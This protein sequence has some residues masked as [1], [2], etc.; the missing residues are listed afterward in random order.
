MKKIISSVLALAMVLCIFP[1]AGISA[2]AAVS[3]TFTYSVNNGIATITD[4]DETVAGTV[5]IPSSLGGYTV[6]EIGDYAFQNCQG[7]TGV[8]IGSNITK[9]GDY[10]FRNCKTLKS[11]SIPNNVVE[12]GYSAFEGCALLNSATIGS[13]LTA[14]PSS[15]FNGC[16]NLET[17]KIGSNVTEI[18]S[19]AFNNCT[20]LTTITWGSNLKKINSSAFYGCSS[21]TSLSIPNTVVTIGDYAFQNCTGLTSLTI[22][23]KVNTIGDYAFRGCSRIKTVTVPNSVTSLGYDT[24][25]GCTLLNSIKIGSGL[26]TIPSSM[27]NGCA[28]LKEVTIGENVTEIGSSAFNNCTGLATITWGSNLKKINSSAFYGCSSLTSLSI[29]NTVVTIGDYAFQNC[30]GVT[31][32]VISKKTTQIGDYAFRNCTLIKKIYIP[33]SLQS[34][35]YSAFSSCSSL[36]DVYYSGSASDWETISIGNDNDALVKATIH[37]NYAKDAIAPTGSISSTNNTA[38]TQTV[39]LTL[40]DNVGIAGYYWGTSSTYTGNTYTS[41]SSKSVTKTITNPG[42]YYLTVKDTSGNIS[43]SY[44]ITFY[45]TTLN[46]NGGSVAPSYIITKKGNTLTFP[47]PTKQGASYNGWSTSSSATGG[48]KSVVPNGNATYYV[49]WKTSK[50]LSNI[51]VV[52]KPTKTVY[53][54]GET[55]NT[56]GLKLKLTYSD[57]STETVSSGFTTAGFDS[58]VAGTKTVTVSYGGKSTAFTVT[59]KGNNPTLRLTDA[60]V[61]KGNTVTIDLAIE[62]NPGF[63]ALAIAIDYNSKY[64]TLV[65]VEN[66]MPSMT[67]T[68]GKNIIW[69]NSSNYTGNGVIARLTFKAAN[70]APDGDYSVTVRSLSAANEEFEEVS[71]GNANAV[72]TVANIIYGDSNGDGKI[73]TVDLAMLR[74]YL[75]NKDPATGE[76]TVSVGAGADVNGDGKINTVDLAMLRKYLADRDPVTGESSVILGPKKQ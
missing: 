19:S 10:A 46:A 37:Y 47:T 6:R 68:Q 56:A 54:V 38:Q 2:Y 17:V 5:T 60:T 13:G 66:K 14:I 39:T 20:G 67:M 11:I 9:I 31:E 23:N 55:L 57:G 35:G 51:S 61:A 50:T 21:L 62:N 8:T 28:N 75:A 30:T 34:I 59:V 1:F 16:G 71:I 26:T 64:L 53:S 25:T 15:M 32:V 49:V 29:P 22:G 3:G 76:S 40:S 73:N 63:C 42:T 74:K 48:V 69:D 65:S 36:H 4:C 41:T 27:V 43:Q 18:G 72:I 45:K 7:I 70:N 33:T 44:S 24:F 52:S 12:V 58:S